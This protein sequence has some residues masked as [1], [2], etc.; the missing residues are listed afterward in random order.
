LKNSPPKHLSRAS[1]TWWRE[2]TREYGITDL[3]GLSL[4]NAAAE[5]RDRAESARAAIQKEGQTIRDRFEQ[6]KPHPLLAAERDA[7]AQFIQAMRAL[8]LDVEP[9]RDGP[10]RPGGR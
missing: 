7:R 9:L 1:K 2:M 8:N 5:A 10:G 4:L 6:V 3:G